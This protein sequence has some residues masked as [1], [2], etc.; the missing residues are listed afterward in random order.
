MPS[1]LDFCAVINAANRYLAF[2]LTPKT[3]ESG[4]SAE[5]GRSVE[6]DR[7]SF[8]TS[9]LTGAIS[10]SLNSVTD[11]FRDPSGNRGAKFPDK[12]FKVLDLKMQNIA[13]GKDPQSVS[14]PPSSTAPSD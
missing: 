14:P 10:S 9:R 4:A 6:R 11:L 3:P 12:L 7:E 13:M 5:G 2:L 8:H 1:L